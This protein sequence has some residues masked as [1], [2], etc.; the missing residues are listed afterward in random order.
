MCAYSGEQLRI[1]APSELHYGPRILHVQVGL[2]CGSENTDL[3]IYAPERLCALF[4][5]IQHQWTTP[6]E[7]AKI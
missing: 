2:A 7:A 1:S 5:E 6:K 4:N 3:Y